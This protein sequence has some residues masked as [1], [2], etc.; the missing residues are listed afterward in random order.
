MNEYI[1]KKAPLRLGYVLACNISKYYA[2]L[3]RRPITFTYTNTCVF[4]AIT[5][6]PITIFSEKERI[7]RIVISSV[8][9]AQFLL[10]IS[11]ADKCNISSVCVLW[12][13]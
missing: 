12:I 13:E 11:N 10:A 7:D 1:G 5:K 4:T 2:A 3:L 9:L 8:I 6:M